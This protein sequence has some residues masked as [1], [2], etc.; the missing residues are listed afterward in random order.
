[1]SIAD[2]ALVKINELNE[3]ELGNDYSEAFWDMLQDLELHPIYEKHILDASYRI[4]F[5]DKSSVLYSESD[6]TW[7]IDVNFDFDY[8]IYSLGI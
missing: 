7:D 5:A 6:N 3:D 8:Y 4:V 1:M 2:I